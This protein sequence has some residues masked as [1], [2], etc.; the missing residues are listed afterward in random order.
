MICGWQKEIQF[1]GK[2]NRKR[3]C[4]SQIFC[5]KFYSVAMGVMEI[6]L[7]FVGNELR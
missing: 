5:T 7:S 2:F 6:F 4:L 1:A 3:Y